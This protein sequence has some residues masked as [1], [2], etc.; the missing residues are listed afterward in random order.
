MN[1]TYK[2][3]A[4][5]QWPIFN[6]ELQERIQRLPHVLVHNNSSEL[7]DDRGRVHLRGRMVRCLKRAAHGLLYNL[8]LVFIVI[9]CKSEHMLNKQLNLKNDIDIRQTLSHVHIIREG[10]QP[11]IDYNIH[12]KVDF[13]HIALAIDYAAGIA[14]L[15]VLAHIHLAGHKVA[16]QV[17]E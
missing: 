16:G 13:L 2:S 4:L 14:E 3:D 8:G 10:I 11:Q 12:E 5:I 9:I 6:I 15:G 7:I 1:Y 17:H